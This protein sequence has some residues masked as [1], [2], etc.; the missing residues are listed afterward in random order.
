MNQSRNYDEIIGPRNECIGY[1]G[2][3]R[4]EEKEEMHANAKLMI[5]A[6]DLLAALKS[7]DEAYCNVSPVMT[8]EDRIEGRKALTAAR[9]AIK[10]AVP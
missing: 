4:E 1:T 10:K 8:R 3:W 9:A 6:P 2:A 5:A 7:M